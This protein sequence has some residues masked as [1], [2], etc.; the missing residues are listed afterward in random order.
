MDDDDNAPNVQATYTSALNNLGVT[1][2]IWDTNNS[3]N[4]PT[5]AQLAAYHTVIW[6]TGAEFG[7]PQGTGTAGPGAAGES[8]LESWLDTNKCLFISS[9]D[10]HY[11]KGLTSFM[12]TYL[13]VASVTDDS[14]NYTSVTGQGAVFGGLGPYALT[15][16]F[17]DFSDIVNP[18]GTAVTAFR[19]NNLNSGAVN[20]DNG[21][22]RTTFWG[23][24]WEAISTA[25]N[26]EQ[27]MQTV[28]DW[29]A[30]P[31]GGTAVWD[32][33]GITNDWSEAINWVGDVVPQATDTVLFDTTSTKDALLD[34]TFPGTV[35]NIIINSG[36]T[37]TITMDRPF[38]VTGDYTQVDGV[39]VVSDPA[40]AVMTVGGN[41][42]HTGGILRQTQTVSGTAV[43]FLHIEDGAT[44]IKYRG[45]TLD[46]TPYSSNLGAVTVN[47]R[48]VDRVTQFCTNTGAMSGPYAGRCFDVTPTIPG[49]A[50]LRLY[51][52]TSELPGG[53]FNPAVYHDTT[54]M[55]NWVRLTT[56]AATGTAGV[57][58][59]AEAEA[60][61]FSPFLIG[62]VV[63]S[64]TAVTLTNLS[65]ANNNTVLLTAVFMLVLLMLTGIF[66]WAQR[67]VK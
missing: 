63:E 47:I 10:Y 22:Y 2:D 6:F 25:V 1:Y 16:P 36:Y 29:C 66:I 48:A 59:Y 51:A 18:D 9:Q 40:T 42:T 37:G 13:G 27:A 7:F 49:T 28:L 57:Y 54:G 60:A 62:D 11:D 44:V 14:G 34:V 46:A 52:L 33:G 5:A 39:F 15:Y 64:P 24:P 4:E 45:A 26:R 23:F 43:P 20:K 55:G 58:T 56:N 65:T 53:T 67:Q 35:A 31:T 32:G 30:P 12:S 3:D 19:G 17:S 41:M 8:A 21:V 50:M 38:T 61:G